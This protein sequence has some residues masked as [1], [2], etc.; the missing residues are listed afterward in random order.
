MTLKSVEPPSVYGDTSDPA[1]HSAPHNRP[2]DLVVAA[3]PL[4]P[5]D[6]ALRIPDNLVISLERVFGSVFVG[7]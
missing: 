2:L 3:R 5:S 6:V 4:S 1:K 7:Q